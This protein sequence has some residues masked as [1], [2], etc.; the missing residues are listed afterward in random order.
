[1]RNRNSGRDFTRNR[2]RAPAKIRGKA[3]KN[4]SRLPAEPRDKPSGGAQWLYGLHAVQAALANP[5]RKLGRALL[6][7]RA[8]ETIGPDLLSGVRV[9]I[10][11]PEAIGKFLPF[12]AVHQGA[13]L[14]TGP[15]PVADLE[16]IL[17]QPSEGRRV[18]L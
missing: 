10:M 2:P 17:D 6:T 14:E 11:D 13:A 18:V 5:R 8:V 4:P 15:L 7:P 16:A 3:E 9:D 12:G 1:M